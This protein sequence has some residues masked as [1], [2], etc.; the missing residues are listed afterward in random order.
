MSSLSEVVKQ[1]ELH[2]TCSNTSVG[3]TL[4]QTL[5]QTGIIPVFVLLHRM[6]HI[7]YLFSLCTLSAKS[8]REAAAVVVASWISPSASHREASPPE[9]SHSRRSELCGVTPGD[10]LTCMALYHLCLQ[11]NCILGPKCM[12]PTGGQG[13]KLA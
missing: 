12:C 13:N 11:T 8:P 3:M 10:K 1:N 2:V 5:G 7:Q 9:I 4:R 6:L